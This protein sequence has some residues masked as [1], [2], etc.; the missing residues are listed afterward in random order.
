MEC[1]S[2]ARLNW[3]IASLFLFGCTEYREPFPENSI[4]SSTDENVETSLFASAEE[5][6]SHRERLMST[7]IA[8]TLKN[9]PGVRNARVHLSLADRSIL[10][11]TP[12]AESKAAILIVQDGDPGQSDAE[13]RAFVTAAVPGLRPENIHIT[14]SR[15]PSQTPSLTNVACFQ[16][17]SESATRLR[18][19]LGGLLGI[20]L[21]C[22]SLL[23]VAG[24]RLR[25]G[26]KL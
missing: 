9:L 14:F 16:V 13:L 20:C 7:E 21:V 1:I 2:Q 3:I 22:A 6:K 10:S 11:G 4:E 18:L 25:K 17:A 19:T 26:R 24:I 15:I 8:R 23:I 5:I 12:P